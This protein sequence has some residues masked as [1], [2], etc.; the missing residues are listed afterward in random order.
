MLKTLTESEFND[1][2]DFAYTLALNP[3]KSGY[4]TY[5]DG[6]KTKSD[7]INSAKKAL[8]SKES[9]ILLFIYNGK[10]EG[11]IQYYF[12]PKDNYLS[13]NAFCINSHTEAAL[14]EFISFAEKEFKGYDLY[15]GFPSDNTEAVSFLSASGFSCIEKDNNNSFFFDSYIPISQNNSVRKITKDGFE[16]FRQLHS[17]AIDEEMYWTS[18]RIYE[19]LERWNIFGFYENNS[20]LGA[21]YFIDNI[22]M[23]EIFGF[24]FSGNEFN[25]KI[26]KEL[27][28]SV[29]NEGKKIGAKYMTYFC[30]KECQPIV[31]ELGFKYVGEYVCYLKKLIE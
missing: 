25:E 17:A 15:L 1:Y 8:T 14:K 22:L 5:T 31:S 12:L 19:K 24:D 2:I 6:I 11:W 21:V 9:D 3:S 7:F 16:D 20:L 18:D 28:I 26:Y 13:T 27:L 4:H 30:E 29:L 10:V 23:L